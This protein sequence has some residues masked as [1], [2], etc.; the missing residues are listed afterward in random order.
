M[1]RGGGELGPLNPQI[2][3]M[4]IQIHALSFL[5]PFLSGTSTGPS[6]SCDGI[7]LDFGPALEIPRSAREA[8]NAKSAR[9]RAV[10]SDLDM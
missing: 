2:K 10:L 1:T 8:Q 5:Q 3:L 4:A 7:A 9:Y 6:P